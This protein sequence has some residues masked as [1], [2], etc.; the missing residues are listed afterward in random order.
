MEKAPPSLEE[1]LNFIDAA[2]LETLEEIQRRMDQR[3]VELPL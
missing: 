1:V 2:S 3:S